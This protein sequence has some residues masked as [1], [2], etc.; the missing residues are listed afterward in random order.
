MPSAPALRLTGLTR[1]F[2]IGL[3]LRRRTVLDAVDLE[4]PRGASLALVGPNGSGK[5]TLLRLIAGVD[6]PSAGRIEVL[7]D[8]PARAM[9]R[10][11]LSYLPEDSPFPPE[12]SARSAM[13]LLGAL[14]GLSRALVR[15]RGDALLEQVGLA[16]QARRPLRTY[17]RG[18]LRRFGLAQAFLSEP[19]LVL[20]DEPTAGLDAQGFGVLE[21]L[22]GEARARGATVVLASHILADLHEHSDHLVVLLG[23]KIAAR[24]TPERMLAVEGRARIEVEG[25][26]G[27]RIEQL[28]RWVADQGGR[29]LAVHPSGRSLLDLYRSAEDQA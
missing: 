2:P 17:S 14:G 18:M 29:V 26:D 5:S 11:R 10:A 8:S 6:R 20:L 16:A 1:R 7:G 28:T 15:A 4:L 9:V 12:L 13:D 21:E 25:L 23:G 22:L 27:G 3:G 19:E 24:G